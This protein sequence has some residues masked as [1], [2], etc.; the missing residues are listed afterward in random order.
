MK[1]SNWRA[2]PENIHCSGSVFKV[3]TSSTLK[4]CKTRTSAGF[5]NISSRMLIRC[6]EQLG[7]I[8]DYIYNLS[9]TQQRVPIWYKQSIIVPVAKTPTP[10]I[11]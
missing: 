1:N 11:L 2:L 10:T 3:K 8:F 7:P 9:L 6:A 4:H 5:D